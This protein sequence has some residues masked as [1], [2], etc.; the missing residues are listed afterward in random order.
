M[1]AHPFHMSGHAVERALDMCVEGDE[2]RRAVE[3]PVD[4]REAH[5][6]RE[7]RTAGRIGVVFDPRAR[8]VVTVVWRYASARK[9]DVLRGDDYGRAAPHRER[10]ATR[11]HKQRRPRQFER[12][13]GRANG[14]DRRCARWDDDERAT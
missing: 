7:V 8:L 13:R 11:E 1:S 4:V 2:I 9:T 5:G 14:R 3:Q 10:A 6:G 12:G